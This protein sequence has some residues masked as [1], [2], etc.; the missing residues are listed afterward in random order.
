MQPIF[1][2]ERGKP[3]VKTNTRPVPGSDVKRYDRG[4]AKLRLERERRAGAGAWRFEKLAHQTK[5]RTTPEAKDSP[6]MKLLTSSRTV[7][8]RDRQRHSPC[9]RHN[10]HTAWGIRRD[11]TSLRPSKTLTNAAEDLTNPSRGRVDFSLDI[12]EDNLKSSA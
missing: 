7:P 2:Q 1:V 10:G 5:K 6:L 4:A 9:N 8:E 12:N 3:T 11:S